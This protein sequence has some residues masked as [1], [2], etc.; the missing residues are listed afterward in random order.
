MILADATADPAK[1]GRTPRDARLRRSPASAR[2][3]CSGRARTSAVE[4][5]ATIIAAEE[6][7]DLEEHWRLL[8]VALTRAGERLVVGGRSSRKG[9]ELR[10]EQLAH[11]GRA[12]AGGARRGARADDAWGAALRYRGSAT[13]AASR[14]KAAGDAARRAVAVPTGRARRRRPKRA[15]RGRWRRRRSAED[16]DAAPPPSA[17]HARGGAARHADP[18]AV[19][20]AA[21]RRAERPPATARCAGSSARPGVADA[22]RARRRS[23]TPSARS[24]SDPRFAALFGPVRSPKRR[25]PRRSPDGRVIAGTVD[26]LLVEDER[27]SVIDFKTGPGARRREADIP[28]AHRAQMAAYAEALRGDLPRP[29]SRGGAALHRRAAICSNSRA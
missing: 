21:R 20:A 5:F 16:D 27:V 19:R 26:R 22:E 15:R 8:Y 13:G 23:P 11:A 25:S 9:G 7:R 10:R 3:R 24:S 12:G 2:R 6:Q 18:P 29:A 4:P 17:E 28:A 14:A 1:L